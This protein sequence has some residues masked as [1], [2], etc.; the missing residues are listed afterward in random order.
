MDLLKAVHDDTVYDGL[1]THPDWI[2]TEKGRVLYRSRVRPRAGD[3][4]RRGRP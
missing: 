2:D 4:R 3:D 1:V